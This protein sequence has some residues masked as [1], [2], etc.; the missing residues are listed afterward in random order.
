MKDS[1]T[2][3]LWSL[4]E[5]KELLREAGRKEPGSVS[6]QKEL[7][8][9]V[10]QKELLRESEQNGLLGEF[11]WDGLLREAGRKELWREFGRKAVESVGLFAALFGLLYI[12][13]CLFP[14]LRGTLLQWDSAAFC[15]GIP[16]SV[17][18]VAYVLTVKNPKNYTGFYGGILMSILLGKQFFL[19][20]NYDL[21]CLQLGVFAPFMTKSI[22]AWKSSDSKNAVNNRKDSDNKNAVNNR[23]AGDSKNASEEP[24]VPQFLHGW[25]AWGTY[26]F[27]VAI[28]VA[29]YALCTL[30]LQHNAWGDNVAVKLCSGLMIASSTLANYW[31]IYRK[32]D[33]WIWWVV[34]S[35]SG[36]VFYILI[37]NMF[38]LVLFTV[39]LFVNGA[40]LRAWMK[41]TINN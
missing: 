17:V 16:A 37:N 26:L 1:G 7:L 32:I 28:V 30:V 31:L 14:A 23:N 9:E 21:V 40:A 11:G 27:A 19:Q 20:G 8:R 5:Q 29:D 39:F 22:L 41:L 3:E 25:A 13:E 10:G 15:V 38:S 24:F 35:L 12:V 33:A 4:S 34:Y 36:M 6:E 2:K 18:G